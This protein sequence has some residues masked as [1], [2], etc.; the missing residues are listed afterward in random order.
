MTRDTATAPASGRAKR[1]LFRRLLRENGDKIYSFAFSLAGNEPDAADLV[2]EAF[3]RALR[4]FGHYEAERDF[5]SWMFKIVQNIY[6][7]R[8][9]RLEHRKTVSIENMAG[10]DEDGG[11]LQDRWESPEPPPD[12]ELLRDEAS[13]NIRKALARLPDAFR[14]PLMLCDMFSMSYGR[15]SET[16]K[17][18]VGTVRSRIFR[19]RQL[20]RDVMRP[21]VEEGGAL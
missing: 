5:H 19:G 9:R 2:A 13:S 6:I 18:P 4:G 16:L 10:R 12:Q 17:V 11:R 7:D 20:L 14:E 1:L 8:K 15:I 3:A 21:Y